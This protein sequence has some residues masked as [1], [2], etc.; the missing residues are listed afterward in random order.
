[1][2]LEVLMKEQ[3]ERLLSCKYLIYV[4][5]FAVIVNAQVQRTKVQYSVKD[6]QSTFSA[7]VTRMADSVV[8]FDISRVM[9]VSSNL[10]V[11]KNLEIK[12]FNYGAY[13]NLSGG[14]TLTIKNMSANSNDSIFRGI[15]TVV[16]DTCAAKFF[17]T[18]WFGPGITYIYRGCP[19]DTIRTNAIKPLSPV[20][21]A[22]GAARLGGMSKSYFDTLK[23]GA[24]S[25]KLN[26]SDTDVFMRVGDAPSLTGDQTTFYNSSDRDR[27]NHTGTQLSS[28]IS[29]FSSV[30]RSSVLSGL[31][32]GRVPYI[33]EANTPSNSPIFI[34]NGV[35]EFINSDFISAGISWISRTSVVDNQW[36]S[37]CYGNGL[38]VAVSSSGTGNRVMS[39]P[40]GI[41]WTSRTSA[42]NNSWTS[43][44]YGNGL[45][46][47]VA[48]NGAGNRVMSSPDGI[49]WTIRTSAADNS[50]TSVC[51]GNG[52]FV[53]VAN[54]GTGNRVMTSP[55]G[56]TW[57]SRV[58][59]T[60]NNWTSV[61][62]GNG[63]FVAV[64]SNGTSNRVMTSPDGVNWTSRVSAEENQFTSV[65][66]GNGLFVAVAYDGAHRSM[67]SPDGINWSAGNI[68]SGQYQAV[69]YGNGIFV[70]IGYYNQ[71][72]TSV[73][74]AN[75]STRAGP[76]NTT[77]HWW[78]GICYGNGVFVTVSRTG[79][80]NRV[81]TSG[82]T[83]S[84]N[85]ESVIKTSDTI[86]DGANR[87]RANHTGTQLSSTISDFTNAVT[88][89]GD[90]RY[91]PLGSGGTPPELTGDVVTHY[92]STDRNRSN[93]T[94]TQVSSTISDFSTAV[95]TVGDARYTLTGHDHNEIYFTESELTNYSLTLNLYRL[96]TNDYIRVDGNDVFHSGNHNSTGDP[97]PQ[98][99]PALS[100][101][102]LSHYHGTD[103]SRANHT[104]TQLSST[105]SDF[106][107]AVTTI[108]DALYT[109]QGHSHDDRYFTEFELTN[110]ETNLALRQVMADEFMMI[111]SNY[112][113]HEGNHGDS[114]NPHPQYSF[115]LSGDV[116]SHY[117][118]TDRNRANHTGTQTASTISDFTAA[119]TAIGDIRYSFTGHFHNDRYY[120]KDEWNNFS[121]GIQPFQVTAYA[122]QIYSPGSGT[123]AVYSALNHG[124]EGDPHPQYRSRSMHTGSQL[125]STISDFTDAV[126][127][128]GDARYA[129]IGTGEGGIP[130][131]LTGDVATHY[132]TSDR[133]RSNHTGTQLSSTISDFATAVA[134]AGDARYSRTN[135]DHNGVYSPLLSGN[136]TTHYHA[137]DRNRAN[138]TGTQLSSTIS[139]FFTA[140]DNAV[141]NTYTT[142]TNVFAYIANGRIPYY[143]G[144]NSR[145][146]SSPISVI[147]YAIGNAAGADNLFYKL[148]PL[149]SYS[150]GTP[151]NRTFNI[152]DTKRN[153]YQFSD[154]DITSFI[155]D[156][157]TVLY[158][159]SLAPGGF[160]LTVR[161][162]SNDDTQNIDLAYGEMVMMVAV[163]GSSGS[164]TV[165][166][167]FKSM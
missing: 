20:D 49:N 94:G 68:T 59:A 100:G 64:A 56:I 148:T 57:T 98:Y 27:S 29:D 161:L 162:K 80:G 160:S 158:V 151:T 60:D 7:Y 77:D 28:T 133:N 125:A 114:G 99:S 5:A 52:L 102:I 120:Q 51:Y 104:G 119:T 88:T 82:K 138:H 4:L 105:I 23:N 87:A 32:T 154:P 3:M 22:A 103:R 53:A 167:A 95:T 150:T 166:K 109:T 137:D 152:N 135:H 65:C 83:I 50:W 93:H 2:L 54:N 165:W 70:G 86:G 76:T 14:P 12:A 66:Y 81:M 113:L 155:A 42:A 134:T 123:Y 145:F 157:G 156:V 132:H 97:H 84:S 130:P 6:T 111:G 90:L 44:C 34:N 139:D 116:S 122:L 92:H 78:R 55:D 25:L 46:V 75:W 142:V 121:L 36:Y 141:R 128:I 163:G 159:Y 85:I 24:I 40:D 9:L 127:T 115:V 131:E 58:S 144:A 19:G 96:L 30:A 110:Y 33:S 101:D 146:G 39:S 72:R 108:T 15:G 48:S 8:S 43:V 149:Q 31:T 143:D 26:V 47:A 140:V 35:V 11:P 21:T 147:N 118:S 16:I 71:I 17:S 117:H 112:V 136:T 91:E 79:T 37:V 69:C 126:T 62:Y 45:F 13:F 106:S 153:F 38:F 74:G 124:S 107:T 41:N 67:Y 1:M 164:W 63:L 61:C 10:T 89:I 129:P 18:R 73:D